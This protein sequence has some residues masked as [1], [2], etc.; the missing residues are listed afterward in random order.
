MENLKKVIK[1]IL[2]EHVMLNKKCEE[3]YG[4]DMDNYEREKI[5]AKEKEAISGSKFEDV[6]AFIDSVET[7]DE[8]VAL[9]EEFYDDVAYDLFGDKR[10]EALECFRRNNQRLDADLDEF[11]DAMSKQK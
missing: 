10:R 9:S 2:A 3:S 11:L 8:L 7:A 6:L 4:Y 1:P 5:W